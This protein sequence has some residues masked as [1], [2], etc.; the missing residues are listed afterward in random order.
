M[1]GFSWKSVPRIFVLFFITLLSVSFIVLLA[2][3]RSA[4]AGTDTYPAPWAPP[5]PQD[6]MFDT[7]REYNRECTSYAAW[8]LHSMNGFEMPF[9]DDAVGWGTDASKLGYTVNMTPTVGSI[10]WST[11]HDHVAWVESVSSDGKTITLKITIQVIRLILAGM[12]RIPEWRLVQ[13][14]VTFTLRI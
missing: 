12:R 8:M 1:T 7:W 4:F 2:D 9:H 6:S 10:Y 13:L 5:A 14:Q 3:S 11:S